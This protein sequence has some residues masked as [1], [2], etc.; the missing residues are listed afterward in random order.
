M[1]IKDIEL[2]LFPTFQFLPNRPKNFF[3]KYGPPFY[4]HLLYL[5]GFWLDFGKRIYNII[6]R[7]QVWRMENGIV[8]AE[9]ALLVLIAPSAQV[10]EKLLN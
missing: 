1:D 5:I 8:L 3:Q 2:D 6:K 4:A 10:L 9:L 7:N